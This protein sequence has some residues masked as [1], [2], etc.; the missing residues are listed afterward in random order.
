ML[1]STLLETGWQFS[2]RSWLTPAGMYGFSKLE[3]LPAEV[4]GHVHLDLVRNGVIADPFASLHE[5]GLRWVDEE[6]WVYRTEFE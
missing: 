4:P 3:W 1:R 6:E 2:A 5:L